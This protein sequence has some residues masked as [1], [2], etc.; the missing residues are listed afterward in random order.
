MAWKIRKRLWPNGRAYWE[1]HNPAENQILIGERG[2]VTRYHI[3]EQAQAARDEMSGK[4][5]KPNPLIEN[6]VT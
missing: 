3:I 2:G 5:A 6:E 1:V 4:A